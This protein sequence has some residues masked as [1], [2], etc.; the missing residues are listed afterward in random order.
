[1]RHAHYFY[2]LL[3][4]YAALL[5]RRGPHYASHSVC[6]SVCPSVPLSVFSAPLASRMYFSARTEGRI[7]YGHLGRTDSCFF[8]S[9]AFIDFI[10][11]AIYICCVFWSLP[12]DLYF[13][14][15]YVF[16]YVWDKLCFWLVTY[17]QAYISHQ[18]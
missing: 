14:P 6:P 1:M 15:I 9:D 4:Y 5:P 17:W 16:L 11:H 12:P 2:L 13:R 8:F 3:R 10:Q 7:S 18:I